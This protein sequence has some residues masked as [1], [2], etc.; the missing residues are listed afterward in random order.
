MKTAA[1]RYTAPQA[2]TTEADW[3]I[4][5]TDNAVN[6][7]DTR[8]LKDDVALATTAATRVCSESC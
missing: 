3:Q 6:Q 1:P 8:K 5:G 7:A 2:P 4:M